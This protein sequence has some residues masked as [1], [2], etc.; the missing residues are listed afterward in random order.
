MPPAN[1]TMVRAPDDR[2]ARKECDSD[3]RVVNCQ[4]L[5]RSLLWNALHLFDDVT[6][7]VDCLSFEAVL[8]G[9]TGRDCCL[10]LDMPSN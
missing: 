8:D 2:A 1:V 5:K 7:T 10:F 6:M 3:C 4:D 9:L